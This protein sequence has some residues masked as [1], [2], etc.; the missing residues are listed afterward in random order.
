[1]PDADLHGDA[2]PGR[3]GVVI[4]A[5]RHDEHASIATL[6]GEYEASSPMF[7]SQG[8]VADRRRKIRFCYRSGS[9]F[10][11]GERRSSLKT[12]SSSQKSVQMRANSVCGGGDGR[13]TAGDLAHE[14]ELV[15]AV[16]RAVVTEDLVEPDVG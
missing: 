13:S 5:Q 6:V 12:S 2:P 8:P 4:R 16:H 9:G 11:Q 7:N 14:I 1:M 10:I 3:L 15:L